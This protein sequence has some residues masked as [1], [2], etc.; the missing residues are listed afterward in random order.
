MIDLTTPDGQWEMLNRFEFKNGHQPPWEWRLRE[1]AALL[2]ADERIYTYG[3]ITPFLGRGDLH[4]KLI[5]E[6][7]PDR[8]ISQLIVEQIIRDHTPE[9][10]A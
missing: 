7:T 3:L 9:W 4:I 1:I 5:P 10:L 6:L 2:V 8:E